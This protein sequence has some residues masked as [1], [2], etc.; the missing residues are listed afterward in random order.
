MRN[1]FCLRNGLDTHHNVISYGIF[2]T[3]SIFTQITRI[4]GIAN[5]LINLMLTEAR[6]TQFETTIRAFD[7]EINFKIINY[8]TEKYEF[9]DPLGYD[10]K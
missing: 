1:F 10:F 2:V 8:A 7:S 9:L 6:F 4:S 5:V 3:A